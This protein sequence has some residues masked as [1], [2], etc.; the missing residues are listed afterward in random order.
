M[1]AVT[2][3]GF[4]ATAAELLAM[5]AAA[6]TAAVP[7]NCRIMINLSFVIGSD[8]QRRCL[9]IVVHKRTAGAADRRRWYGSLSPGKA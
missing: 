2:A 7:E 6:M 3:G 5:R 1:G 9:S 8:A 4:P